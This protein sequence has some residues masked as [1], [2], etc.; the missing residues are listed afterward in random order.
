LAKKHASFIPLL[1]A[2]FAVVVWGASFIATKIA[3]H[4]VSPMT[5]VWLRFGIGVALLGA[6]VAA[7]KEFAFVSLKEL[8]YFSLLGFLGITF[9]QWLQST[10]LQTSKATTT[11]WIV[12]TIPIF[13]A[14]LGWFILRERLGVLG[15]V[16]I[17]LAAFGVLLVVSQ[18]DLGALTRGRFGVI[19][20]VLVLISAP[21]WAVFSVVSRRGLKKHPPTRM[22]FYVMITGWLFT[23][24]WFT[25]GSGYN[26]VSR[27]TTD[28]WIGILFLGV[29][30]SGL[31]YIYW[32][33]ALKEIPASKVGSLL[34]LEPLVAVVVASVFLHEALF[35]AA[36]VG[37]ALILAGVWLVN[38]PNIT[39]APPD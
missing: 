22:M 36:F 10:G 34:Y 26:E 1:K 24:V 11:A 12:A 16:G 5:V 4:D 17:L 6:F 35:L 38:R 8:G 39:D 33:D 27:L 20:D 28:G 31:A 18:G 32:Y 21:N 25:A 3:L 23:S 29:F 7:R 30:C 9:H 15:V 19:G 2:F 14:L 37:G 13:I